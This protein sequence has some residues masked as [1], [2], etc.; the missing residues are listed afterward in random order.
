MQFARLVPFI[1]AVYGAPSAISDLSTAAEDADS[2]DQ[3]ESYRHGDILILDPWAKSAIGEHRVKLFFEFRN[4]GAASDRLLRVDSSPD[5]G[6]ARIIA[7]EL[8]DDGIR[9]S[10]EI[11]SLE[12]PTGQSAFELSEHG[13]YIELTDLSRPVLMGSKIPLVLNFE[14]AGE[15]MIEFTARFHS[16]SLNRRIKEAAARGDVEMLKKLRPD[17]ED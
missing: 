4:L 7:V 2:A 6:T 5:D 11:P 12:I 10:R 13:Y 16:P 3:A 17:A 14:K 8:N 1:L 15:I 9:T